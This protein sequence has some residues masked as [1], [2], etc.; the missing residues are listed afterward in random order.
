MK[1]LNKKWLYSLC[2]VVVLV[3][4]SLTSNAQTNASSAVDFGSFAPSGRNYDYLPV[5][6]TDPACVNNYGMD[7]NDYWMKITITSSCR[8]TV[9]HGST[10]GSDVYDSVLHLLDS[11]QNHLTT[12]DDRDPP[13]DVRA[14]ID[15]YYVTPGDY[16][17]ILDGTSSKGHQKN[18]G[19]SLYV[20][21]RS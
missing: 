11:S 4:S 15:N 20:N 19:I 17:I 16:Y 7:G 8:L 9:S 2:A 3:T 1:N 18:G 14:N 21:I 13:T 5:Y 6:T 12:D 10:S